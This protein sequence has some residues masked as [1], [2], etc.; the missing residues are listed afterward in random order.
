ML[1]MALRKGAI[2]D[3]GGIRMVDIPQRDKH[4]DRLVGR[5][6][7][8]KPNAV[9]G[10]DVQNL[11]QS[12]TASRCVVRVGKWRRTRKCESADKRMAPRAYPVL[13]D[14]RKTRKEG[15]RNE[16]VKQCINQSINQSINELLDIK[17]Q[18]A[19]LRNVDAKGMRPPCAAMPLHRAA[20]ACSR[21]P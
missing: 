8:T 1:G 14:S 6:V 19:K 2:S 4:L 16:T 12:K 17:K 18:P 7:L 5:P 3:E 13:N 15:K 10:H 21:T 11:P 20:I 9:V